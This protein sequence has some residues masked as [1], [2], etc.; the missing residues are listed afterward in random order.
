MIVKNLTKIIGTSEST[1]TEW[2]QSLS[3]INEIIE[4]AVAFVNTEGGKIFVGVSKIGKALGAQIGKG[5]I[6][7]L[8]NQISQHTDP[9][10]HPEITIKKIDGKE[11]IV[12]E[13][14]ESP[15]HLVL[16]FGRPYKRVGRSS[17]RMSK[18]EYEQLILEK[19]KDES[20]FDKDI[21]IETR[22]Y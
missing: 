19:H 5:T 11:I 7:N 16:A 22:L 15:D 14:K 2:K 12:I 18:D 8:V 20:E 6:E 13:V 21:C 1:T 10:L 17:P 4:T 9:K 3:E